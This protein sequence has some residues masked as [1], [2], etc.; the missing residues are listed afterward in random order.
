MTFTKTEDGEKI[1]AI[2]ST[3]RTV[4]YIEKD[5]FGSHGHWK[6]YLHYIFCEKLG[7]LI[8]AGVDEYMIY[9]DRPHESWKSW[10]EAPPWFPNVKEFKTY[11]SE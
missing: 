10:T 2:D 9:P 3:G 7:K 4:A 6:G 5:R 1:L 11:Y 8:W